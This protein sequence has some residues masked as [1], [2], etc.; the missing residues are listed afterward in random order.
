MTQTLYENFQ[1]GDLFVSKV[2][3]EFIL[4]T[5]VCHTISSVDIRYI[6]FQKHQTCTF[7]RFFVKIGDEVF[8][9]SFLNPNWW[10]CLKAPQNKKIC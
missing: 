7:S 3:K 9:E 2:Y 4:I 8:T 5:K 1:I 6:L 10:Y